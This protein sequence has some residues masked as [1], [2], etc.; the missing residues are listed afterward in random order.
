MG[1][2]EVVLLLDT[3]VLVWLAVA[4][5]KLSRVAASTIRRATRSDGIGIASITLWE[6]AVLFARGRLQSHGSVESSVERLVTATRVVV[7]DLT[8][9]VAAI[10]SQLPPDFPADP[11]D[12]LIAATARAEGL[13]LVTADARILESP[14]V[15]TVW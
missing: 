1:G 2:A 6:L 4:P 8:P 5:R 11:A 10:A 15:K 9:S 3:H 7:K 14:L 13:A 12:R